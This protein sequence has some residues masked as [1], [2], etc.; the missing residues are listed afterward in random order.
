MRPLTRNQVIVW[1]IILTAAIELLTVLMR[2][3]FKMQARHGSALGVRTLTHGV[4]IHHGYIGVALILVAQ[5]VLVGRPLLSRWVLVIGIALL[6][7]DL[8]HHF[9]VLWPITGSPEFDLFYRQR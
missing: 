7:S 5:A 1:S 6:A 9:A 8:I 3:G 4:R 2:F